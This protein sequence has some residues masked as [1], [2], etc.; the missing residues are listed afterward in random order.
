LSYVTP[1]VRGNR[2]PVEALV[3]VGHGGSGGSGSSSGR[4]GGKRSSRTF[5][6]CF[7]QDDQVEFCEIVYVHVVPEIRS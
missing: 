6:K 5:D 2:A 3:R 4:R 7:I 1:L